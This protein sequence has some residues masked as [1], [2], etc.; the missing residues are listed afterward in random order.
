[1]LYN[2]QWRPRGVVDL[3]AWLETR[4]PGEYYN[5]HS[6]SRCLIAQWMGNSVDW[7]VEIKIIYKGHDPGAIAY[8]SG[9]PEDWTFGAALARARAALAAEAA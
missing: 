8:G 4:D 1:M 2:P 6:C 3:I 5:Y 7:P 9:A